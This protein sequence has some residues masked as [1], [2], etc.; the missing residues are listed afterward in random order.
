MLVF[1][2]SYLFL[3]LSNIVMQ[4]SGLLHIKC[5]DGLIAI[6][7]EDSKQMSKCCL[8]HSE[9]KLM[10]EVWYEHGVKIKPKAWKLL[11]KRILNVC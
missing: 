3:N 7:M 5:L 6:H 10:H 11:R 4:E 1:V 2:D 8:P 9:L